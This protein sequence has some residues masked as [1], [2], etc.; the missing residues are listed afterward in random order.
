MTTYLDKIYSKKKFDRDIVRKTVEGPVRDVVSKYLDGMSEDH[1]TELCS[2]KHLVIP[3]RELLQITDNDTSHMEIVSK[4]LSEPVFVTV[5]K[6]STFMETQQLTIKHINNV[7]LN[8][9]K[10]R[11]TGL[12]VSPYSFSD[13]PPIVHEIMSIH[14]KY[15]Y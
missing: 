13:A 4:Y 5:P 7:M 2:K 6:T 1:F 14:V 15:M 12:V 3:G 9:C 11:F 8:V 10:E